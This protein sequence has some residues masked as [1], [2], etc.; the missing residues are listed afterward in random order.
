MKVPEKIIENGPK[1]MKLKGGACFDALKQ[2]EFFPSSPK[3]PW[4]ERTRKRMKFY[5]VHKRNH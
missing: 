2:K 5:S 1:L 4:E 3:P